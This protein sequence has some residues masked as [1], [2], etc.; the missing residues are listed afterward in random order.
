MHWIFLD[1]IPWDYDVATPLVRPLGGSQSALCYLAAAL[2]RRGHEVT[3]LTG[4]S[5]PRTIDGVKCLRHED[6]PAEL[7]QRA[8]T[9]TVAVNGPATIAEQLRQAGPSGP[10]VLWTGHAHDQP[11]VAALADRGCLALWDQVVCVSHW[12]RS[13][14]EE[15]LGVPPA[16]ISVLRNAISPRFERLFPSPAALARAKPTAPRLAYTSTPFRGLDLLI[17]SF[18]EIRR[19]HPAAEL[20]VFSSMQVYGGAGTA[21]PYEPLYAHCRSSPG[22]RYHGSVSQTELAAALAGSVVFAY[23]NTFPE[24]SCIA[25]LEALAA[26]MAVV[27]SRLGALPETCGDWASFIPPI[28]AERSP[29]RFAVD[30]IHAVDRV[31]REIASDRAG[32]AERQFAQVEAINAA[33]TWNQRAADWEEAAARW[34]RGATA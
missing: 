30:F 32:F 1:A 34:F 13:M 18:P 15:R 9:V 21:D 20:D 12:H 5:Q 24:T 7:F 3:T 14:F 17:A 27:T 22:V 16:K 4:T 10:L 26:G 11:A 23:P 29:E 8:E 19:R 28:A 2:A 25:A 6:I 31:L 33:Y